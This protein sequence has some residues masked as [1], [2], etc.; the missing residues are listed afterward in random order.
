VHQVIQKFIY[1]MYSVMVN[2]SVSL[3]APYL[4]R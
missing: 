4:E 2:V 1:F 3:T